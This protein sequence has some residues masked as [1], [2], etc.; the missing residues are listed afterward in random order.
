[1]KKIISIIILSFFCFSCNPHKNKVNPF[2][3]KI[4]TFEEFRVE[5]QEYLNIFDVPIGTYFWDEF[6]EFEKQYNLTK[7]E[8][9]LLGE[10]IITTFTGG[11]INHDYLYFPNKFFFMNFF[12]RTIQITDAKN[13][14]LNKALGTWEIIDGMVKITIYAIMTEDEEKIYPDN[15]DIFLVKHPYTIDFINIDD[16]GE[17]GFTKRPINDAILSEELLKTVTIL[18]PN[19]SN[20]LFIRNVYTIDLVPETKKN[21]NYFTYFPEM[22]RDNHSGLEIA[23]NPEL[24]KKYIP[25]WMF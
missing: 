23:T 2:S 12:P 10:W 16:I 4:Y 8:S 25:D 6:S 17:E 7:D 13:L 5:F 21:Y 22:A 3:E 18:K 15:K 19:T 9:K 24:I 14:F 11:P 20:N 1:M